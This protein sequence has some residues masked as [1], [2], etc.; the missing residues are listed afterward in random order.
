[1]KEIIQFLEQCE[2]PQDPTRARK[3]AVQGPLFT[4]VDD[5]LFYLDPKHSDRRR[6]VVP[7]HIR[8][9]VMEENHHGAMGGHFSGNRLYNA[10]AH[11]CGGKECTQMSSTIPETVLNVLSSLVEDDN[12]DPHFTQSQ[13][14]DLSKSLELISWNYPEHKGTSMW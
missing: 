8:G 6:A 9:R 14:R 2:L 5:V 10:L 3:I 1:M 13:Y 4:L 12:I 11:H 7:E